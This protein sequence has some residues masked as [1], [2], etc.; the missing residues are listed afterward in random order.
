MF[1][2]I[3][4]F[5]ILVLSMASIAK[6]RFKKA[7]VVQILFGVH[8]R[9]LELD[10]GA[11]D[12]KLLL[13]VAATAGIKTRPL[14]TELA[15]QLRFPRSCAV[16]IQDAA[17]EQHV[18]WSM[19]IHLRSLVLLI[20]SVREYLT[21][22]LKHPTFYNAINTVLFPDHLA[23]LWK[24]SVQEIH[25]TDCYGMHVPEQGRVLMARASAVKASIRALKASIQAC[26]ASI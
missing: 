18:A 22:L 3:A 10:F 23:A 5:V 26:K 25:K 4:I 1:D 21:K 17:K 15:A 14:I 19:S 24:M 20:R 12:E 7:Q 2:Q 16:A 8:S 11:T 9:L 6:A 13:A